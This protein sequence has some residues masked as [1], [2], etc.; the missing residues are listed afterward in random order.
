MVYLVP[1]PRYTEISVENRKNLRPS[2]ILRPRWSGFPWNWVPVLRVKKTRMM[3]LYWAE[4]EVW[5]YLQPS[6]YNTPTWRTVTERQQRPRLRMASRGK[7]HY[8]YKEIWK[9]YCSQHG[10]IAGRLICHNRC[11]A[12][13]MQLKWIVRLDMFLPS[14]SI[15]QTG[16]VYVVKRPY[17]PS[18]SFIV[19][20]I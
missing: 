7:N 10:R 16:V 13:K 6:G 20:Y 9:K 19:V 1:F 8:A 14:K 3:R 17:R 15:S 2:C 4:K 12:L 18:I 11:V 5:R